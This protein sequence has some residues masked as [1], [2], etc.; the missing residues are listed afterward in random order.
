MCGCLRTTRRRTVLRQESRN[1]K[2]RNRSLL[3][4][5]R[6]AT[7]KS[8]TRVIQRQPTQLYINILQLHVRVICVASHPSTT[9]LW[10][11]LEIKLSQVNFVVREVHGDECLMQSLVHSELR[12]S[13]CPKQL[14]LSRGSLRCHSEDSRLAVWHFLA[15]FTYLA[16][17]FWASDCLRSDKRSSVQCF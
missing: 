6:R 12:F 2:W 1:L 13:G 9:C 11:A 14:I 16:V 3:Y 4:R 7:T 15:L 17:N 5:S 8:F 10:L